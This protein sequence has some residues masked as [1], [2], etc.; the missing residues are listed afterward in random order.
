MA[1]DLTP[2]QKELGKANFQRVTEGLTR[3]DFMKSMALTAGV[4]APVSAAAYFQ[5]SSGKVEGKPVKT[6]LI[7]AGDE[8]GVLI[9]YH[10]PRYLEVVAVCDIRPTNKKRI[11]TGDPDWEKKNSPRK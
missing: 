3:R 5:Y 1:L 7:G 9:G 4:V 10:N 8:G 11:F 2:E 6:A